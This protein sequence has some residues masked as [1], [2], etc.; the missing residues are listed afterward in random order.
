MKTEEDLKIEYLEKLGYLEKLMK[1]LNTP[2]EIFKLNLRVAFKLFFVPISIA[3]VIILI[4]EF[5]SKSF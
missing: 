4:F 3:I 2:K 5:L 1:N